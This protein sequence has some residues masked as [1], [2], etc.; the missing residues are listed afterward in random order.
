[1]KRMLMIVGI[2]LALLFGWY[3]V[4]KGLFFWY[5]SHFEMPPVTV[6][7]SQAYAK[8]WQ[9]YLPSVGSVTAINGVDIAAEVPGIVREI[10]FTPGQ[11][12]RKGDI[13]IVLDTSV[14]Q[15]ELKS[16]DAKLKLAKINHQRH[17]TLL[18]KNAISQAVLDATQAELQEAEAAVEATQAR[19]NQKTIAAAFDGRVGIRLVDIGEYISP[20]KPLVTLQSLNPLFANFSLPEQYVA[21]LY[22]QQPV[23]VSVNLHNDSGQTIRGFINGINAKVDQTTRNILVQA[24]I[25]NVKLDLYPGMFAVIKVWLP[26]QKKVVTLPQTA[27]AYSLHG[28]YVFIIKQKGKTKDDKPIL[29]AYR[30]YVTVGEHR[31]N[32]V[33]ILKG[34]E[35]GALVVTAGQLKLQNGTRVLINNEVE[36]SPA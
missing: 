16:N 8:T 14:E 27:I 9:A 12:V 23:D 21:N 26:A 10:R 1:M 7:T 13:L 18:Q 6:A 4:K 30:Q 22:F 32:E 33:A 29:N 17:Q 20:G 28:D 11:W 19:I 15:A 34:I 35:P 25:P 3:G 24:T 2:A 5:M 36:L 31:G